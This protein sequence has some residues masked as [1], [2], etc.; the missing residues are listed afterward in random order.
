MGIF[1]EAEIEVDRA[2]RT[3]ALA[4]NQ[5][6]DTIGALAPLRQSGTATGTTFANGTFNGGPF[7][8]YLLADEV[9]I[10]DGVLGP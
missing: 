10:A 3:I 8:G 5:A 4:V 9:T 6:I 2:Q 1:T 7:L